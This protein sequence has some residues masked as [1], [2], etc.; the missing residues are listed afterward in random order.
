[1]TGAGTVTGTGV[2]AE[3]EAEAEAG[4]GMEKKGAEVG[5]GTA[6]TETA[7]IMDRVTVMYVIVIR[8]INSQTR[9][10]PVTKDMI[11]MVSCQ[12]ILNQGESRLNRIS[13]PILV[14]IST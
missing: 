1:M 5:T 2:E 11:I 4:I 12:C 9:R 13:V 3:A 7:E 10:D 6:E 8:L 14:A